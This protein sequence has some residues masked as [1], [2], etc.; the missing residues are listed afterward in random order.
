PGSASQSTTPVRPTSDFAC[1][2]SMFQCRMPPPALVMLNAP[3][4]L[5]PSRTLNARSAGSTSITAGSGASQVTVTSVTSWSTIAPSSFV[6]EH[7]WN[8]TGGCDTLTLQ[9]SPDANACA[10]VN[11]PFAATVSSS[12]SPLPVSRRSSMSPPT[13]PATLPPTLYDGVPL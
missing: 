12:S 3:F 9:V 13:M 1:A 4:A 11:S 8:G 7:C 6:T 2:V 5:P 10:N